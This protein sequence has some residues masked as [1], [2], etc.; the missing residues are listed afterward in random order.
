MQCNLSVLLM[1]L[2][3]SRILEPS[4]TGFVWFGHAWLLLGHWLAVWKCHCGSRDKAHYSH[5][6]GHTD[7]AHNTVLSDSPVATK[8]RS[9]EQQ[10]KLLET[11]IEALKNRYLKPTGLRLLYEEQL[12]ELKRLADQMRVQ[13][14]DISPSNGSF[15]KSWA[16]N[17]ILKVYNKCTPATLTCSHVDEWN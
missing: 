6:C 17:N 7:R 8:V 16:S 3:T 13:R 1:L 10:N 12:Q 4:L 11:E 14:V 2:E 5:F 15:D 9:L